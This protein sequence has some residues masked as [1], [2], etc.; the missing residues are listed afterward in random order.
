V[1]NLAIEPVS[2]HPGDSQS[3]NTPKVRF[4]FTVG[5]EPIIE[6]ALV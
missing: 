3:Y 4:S 6:V 2:I 1:A 5:E